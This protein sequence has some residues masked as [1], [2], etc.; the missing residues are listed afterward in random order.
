MPARI[1][2]VSGDKIDVQH[3]AEDVR[4]MLAQGDDLL[5]LTGAGDAQVWVNPAAV[6][7]IAERTPAEPFVEVLE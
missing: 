5:P 7:Y 1:V 6:G 3:D 2:L 4:K